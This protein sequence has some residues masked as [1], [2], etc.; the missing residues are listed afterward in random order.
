MRQFDWASYRKE[1]SGKAAQVY[2]RSQSEAPKRLV[3]RKPRAE[4]ERSL[5]TRQVLALWKSQLESGRLEILGPRR[6]RLHIPR[7][8]GPHED[9]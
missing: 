1:V 2:I 7:G 5:L 9:A 3:R 4:A 8:G 6:F